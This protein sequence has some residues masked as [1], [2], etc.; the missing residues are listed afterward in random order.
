MCVP[1]CQVKDSFIMRAQWA[2]VVAQLV[3]WSIPIPEVRSSNPVIGKK[4][5]WTFTVNFI[6]KAKIKQKVAGNGLFL[7]KQ[8]KLTSVTRWLDYIF[9]I[10]PFTTRKFVQKYQNFP[11]Y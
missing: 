2:V 10:W 6:E 4:L 8:C 11:K 3:E 5:Y 9:E 1:V 7:K